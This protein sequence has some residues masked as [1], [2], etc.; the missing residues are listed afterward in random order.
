MTAARNEL[1]RLV[2][3][4]PND[5]VSAALA[6]VQRLRVPSAATTWP[7]PWFGAIATDRTDIS[8]TTDEALA[9]GFG[10]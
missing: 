10:R 9:D 3:Q 1:R 4:L 6:E 8:A 5:Q 2:E 7:P